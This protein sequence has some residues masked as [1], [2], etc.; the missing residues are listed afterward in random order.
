MVC[1]FANL[2]AFERCVIPGVT[3]RQLAKCLRGSLFLRIAGM[4]KT[5]FG[6][7]HLPI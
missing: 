4:V 3:R 5:I 1:G 7:P 6:Q 2:T